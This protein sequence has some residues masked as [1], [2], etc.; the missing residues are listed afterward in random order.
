MRV[1]GAAIPAARFGAHSPP[2]RWY[3]GEHLALSERSRATR[4]AHGVFAR[5]A[6]EHG[7]QK[8]RGPGHAVYVN[9]AR[10]ND[11]QQQQG[12]TGGQTCPDTPLGGV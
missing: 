1:N 7:M 2:S 6:P 10:H 8:E 4:P 12:K 3:E 11:Q 9:E 5:D